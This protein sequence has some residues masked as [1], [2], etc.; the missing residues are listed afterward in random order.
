MT[1]RWGRRHLEEDQNGAFA[2]SLAVPRIKHKC[3]PQHMDPHLH[4]NKPEVFIPVKAKARMHCSMS[5]QERMSLQHRQHA[6][7]SQQEDGGYA[8]GTEVM[9]KY[10]TSD[11]SA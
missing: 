11:G 4:G 2:D 7:S 3:H 1:K 9:N 5:H 6:T 8:P 10:C